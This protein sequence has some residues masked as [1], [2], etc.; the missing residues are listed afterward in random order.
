MYWLRALLN[1]HVLANLLFTLIL[2][3]GGIS[4]FSMPRAN[5]PEV[6]FNW[7]NITTVL[8]GASAIDVEKRVT[9]PL[10]DAIRSSVKDTRYVTSTSRDSISNILVRFEEID[11]RT[12]DKRVVDLRREVQN[13][14][15]DILPQEAEDPYVFEVTSS[16]SFPTASVVITSAGND[17]NLR[18]QTRNIQKDLELIGGVVNDGNENKEKNIFCGS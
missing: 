17:E 14:Y 16:N 18:I 10:E 3:T 8:P 1:N 7:T 6:N 13:K 2:V 11:E 15:L 12:F 5:D 9:D 4:Y